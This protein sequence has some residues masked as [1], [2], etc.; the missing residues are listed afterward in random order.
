MTYE[1]LRFFKTWFFVCY[2]SF[3]T[4]VALLLRFLV[5]SGLYLVRDLF[6]RRYLSAQDIL[7][8][9]GG[10]PRFEYLIVYFAFCTNNFQWLTNSRVE[11]IRN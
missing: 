6:L 7:Q 3:K 1:H 11:V 9:P 2:Y 10:I 8:N 5:W 4:W